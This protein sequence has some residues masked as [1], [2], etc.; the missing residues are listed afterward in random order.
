MIIKL[1]QIQQKY[2]LSLEELSL[3][4]F[5]LFR[6][7]LRIIKTKEAPI[8]EDLR[9]YVLANDKKKRVSNYYQCMILGIE[10]KVLENYDNENEFPILTRHETIK[11]IK[12]LK[13]TN[14]N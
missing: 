3:L 4:I 6:R 9:L 8:L 13:S 12:G 14:T 10:K 2:D 5:K 1:E 7:R 11:L